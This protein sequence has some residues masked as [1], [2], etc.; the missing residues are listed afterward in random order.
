MTQSN[1]SQKCPIWAL[2]TKKDHWRAVIL[3][4]KVVHQIWTCTLK[5]NNLLEE[6]FT[7]GKYLMLT[8]IRD[9]SV[10]YVTFCSR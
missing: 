3:K 10:S 4:V 6:C 9:Y 8:I 5:N 1:L 7:T 2:P